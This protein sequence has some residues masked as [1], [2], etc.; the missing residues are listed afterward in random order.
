MSEKRNEQLRTLFKE[1]QILSS[2]LPIKV[3]SVTWEKI[4]VGCERCKQ[5]IP[6]NMLRGSITSLIPS[7]VT[8]EGVALCKDCLLM[9]YVKYRFRSDGSMEYVKDGVWVRNYGQ[10]ESLFTRFIEVLKSKFMA[11]IKE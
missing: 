8:V 3:S 7:V 6:D 1:S 9:H 5:D 2:Q 10:K 4:T 11:K